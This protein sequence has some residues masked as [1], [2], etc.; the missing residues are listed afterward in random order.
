MV[1]RAREMSAKH[2]KEN[3]DSAAE[4]FAILPLLASGLPVVRPYTSSASSREKAKNYF[5]EIIPLLRI[6]WDGHFLTLLVIWRH[7]PWGIFRRWARF[8]GQSVYDSL[9]RTFRI[10]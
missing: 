1:D 6:A 7:T 9:W 4:Q 3:N 2:Q 8:F 10:S 5:A